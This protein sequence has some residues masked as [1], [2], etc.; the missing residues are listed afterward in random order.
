MAASPDIR[1]TA[2][3]LR[4]PY[5]APRTPAWRA[6]RACTHASLL[7]PSSGVRAPRATERAKAGRETPAPRFG[8]RCSRMYGIEVRL[9]GGAAYG[10]CQVS[11]RAAA[12]LA[13]AAWRPCLIVGLNP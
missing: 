4:L 12:C 8:L 6:W 1:L 10:N 7:V 3:S 2:S 11:A 9:L 5:R 13:L